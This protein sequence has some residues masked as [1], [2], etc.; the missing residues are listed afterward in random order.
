MLV[1]VVNSIAWIMV[2]TVKLAQEARVTPMLLSSSPNFPHASIPPYTY[3]Y[4]QFSYL[5]LS[6]VRLLVF[7]SFFFFVTWVSLFW[8]TFWGTLLWPPTLSI[9]RNARQPLR[10][11]RGLNLDKEWFSN[12]ATKSQVSEVL[13]FK[14][15]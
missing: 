14:Y 1:F 6:L 12:V 5:T 3:I 9:V 15:V 2:I 8:W 4:C 7:L 13:Y 11:G 10:L